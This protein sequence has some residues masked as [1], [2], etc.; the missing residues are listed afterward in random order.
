MKLLKENTIRIIKSTVPVL[1]QHGLTIT[2]CFYRNMFA[3]HPEL[4]HVFNHANQHQERQQMALANAVLA[5]A[6]HIDQ[7]STIIPVVEQ[8]A[9][10]HRSLGVKKEHYPIVGHHLL[11]AI[12]EVLGEA[13]TEDILQAWAEAYGIIADVFISVES[14]LYQQAEN[15]H[16][17]WEGFRP[18]IV[19]RK[20]PEGEQ[21]ISLYL[22]PQDEG[23]LPAFEPGQYV[24]VKV[25]MPEESY[26]HIR[27]YSLSHAPDASYYRISVKREEAVEGRPAGKVSMFLH[28]EVQEG[29]VLYLS[30][31]AGDFTLKVQDDRPR[32]WISAGVGITPMISMIEAHSKQA[33]RPPAVFIHAAADGPSHAFREEVASWQEHTTDAKI[34]FC[35][36]NP[37]DMDREE[38]R[39]QHEGR[40][41]AEWLQTLLPAESAVYY[42]CGSAAFMEQMVSDL[43]ELGVQESDIYAEYFG[44]KG[45]LKLA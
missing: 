2:K 42:V 4:L 41:D 9:H 44:P 15:Q 21:I 20:Q 32:V 19:Q 28:D 45:S 29:A 6:K 23:A 38:Q 5:A 36:S 16:G 17:G 3:E 22:V 18:F 34:Y 10:K 8:I 27:Q 43:K 31:P 7:L 12:K 40:I 1:E 25:E 13:A 11:G 26:T 14:D 37:T 33:V 35:Y 39:Y 24:S 30:A